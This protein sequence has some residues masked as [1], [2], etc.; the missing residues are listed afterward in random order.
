MLVD[1]DLP[2]AYQTPPDK[3]KK[4]QKDRMRDWQSDRSAVLSKHFSELHKD[5]VRVGRPMFVDM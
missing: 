5:F 1:I 3:R 4:R 2:T